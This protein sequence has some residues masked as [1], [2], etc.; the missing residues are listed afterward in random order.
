MKR[1]FELVPR[2]AILLALATTPALAQTKP[3][4]TP[5]PSG[6]SGIGWHGWG[7]QVGVSA[8]PDQLFFGAHFNLG[9]FAKNVRFR[10]TVDLGTG[11]DR[12]LLTALGEVHYVFPQSKVWKPYVGGGAGFTYVNFNS[13]REKHG[14]DDGTSFSLAALGGVETRM[15]SGT[16]LFFEGKL[17]FGDEDPNFKAAVGW[18]WK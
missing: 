3:S 12:T 8:D 5:P 14:D 4:G 7:V 1:R 9:E 18:S 10:P 11:D 2:L 13:D 17:G 16:R 15:K 6:T